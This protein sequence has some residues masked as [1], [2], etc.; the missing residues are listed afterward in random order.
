MPSDQLASPSSRNAAEDFQRI[1]EELRALPQWVCWKLETVG[2]RLTKVPYSAT[3]SKASSTD[4]ATWASFDDCQAAYRNGGQFSG[5]G[6]VFTDGNG[7][8]G[9]DLDKHRDPAT[10][11]LDEFAK[12][13]VARLDS[14]TEASQSGTGVH[15][16][17][18]GVIPSDKG[19]RDAKQGLEMYS[20]ARFFVMTGQHLDDTPS[21]IERRQS[22]VSGL[23][24]EVFGERR[25][26]TKPAPAPAQS[27]ALT[28][29]DL[30]NRASRASNGATFSALWR[31][32]FASAGF[33]SQSEADGSLL[34]MLHFWTGGDKDRSFRLFAQ[35]GLNRDKWERADYR[36]STW[37]LVANGKTYS[38]QSAARADAL[39]PVTA[40][41]SQSA[42]TP[43]PPSAKR[44]SQLDRRTENDPT[45]LLKSAYLCQGGG[46]LF[47]AP[48][49][50][51][52]SAAREQAAM[53][54]G[55]GLPFCG[56]V[57]AR[58]LKSLIIQAE[59]DE[60]DEA[61]FADG[62]AQGLRFTPDQIKQADANVITA[63]EDSRTGLP[64]CLYTIEPL[65][66]AHRPDLVWL[67]PANSYL[68]GDANAQEVVGGFLRNMLNPLLRKYACA[69]IVIHHTAKPPRGKEKG[70]WQ[71]GD[72]AYL[73]SGSAEFAN[74]ARC[75]L[76]IRSIGQHAVFELRA[77]KRGSRIGWKDD[78]GQ[79]AYSRFIAHSKEPGLIYWRDADPDE[80]QSADA[81]RAKT[82][83]DL[84]AL[85]PLAKPILKS[86]LLDRAQGAGI[87]KNRARTLLE[88]LLNDERLYVWERKRTGTN[89][90]KLIARKPEEKP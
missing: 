23:F 77:G 66:A 41:R 67:D 54:W 30:V 2:E 33:G 81:P 8:T 18:R 88:I 47:V 19:K 86:E 40:T 46:A 65:L 24:Q 71:A 51:G 90:A 87:G 53:C 37:A 44:L 62:I 63:R 3:G 69:C 59:N 79:P 78:N 76:A 70:D 73:G 13:I 82:P 11:E 42:E 68:G 39:R 43:Q 21:M 32:D 16:I 52:K 80:A 75:V 36:E 57:P 85:V 20:N 26:E 89:P 9:I 7:L 6:F 4:P 27:L 74:W 17:V 83:E 1:P 25:Q 48:T 31:G 34:S 10:G 12:P 15:I 29:N 22:A 55:V 14:Y 5:L 35:S 58:P 61:E 28:D 49:G 38:L 56:I 64:L 72:F 45:E 60:G 84:I 50:V